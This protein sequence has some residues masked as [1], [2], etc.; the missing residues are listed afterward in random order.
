MIEE[1]S[2]DGDSDCRG[3][4]PKDIWRVCEERLILGEVIEA[5]VFDLH[6]LELLE[7]GIRVAP[8]PPL[9]EP[10]PIGEHLAERRF[11]FLQVEPA[12]RRLEQPFRSNFRSRSVEPERLLLGAPKLVASETLSAGEVESA[13]ET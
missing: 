13:E 5:E 7:V 1:L 9:V 3:S 12:E 6:Q 4:I 10:D 2:V 11:C 8:P